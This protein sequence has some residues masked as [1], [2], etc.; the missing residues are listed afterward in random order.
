LCVG[1]KANVLQSFGFVRLFAALL[2]LQKRWHFIFHFSV[3][4]LSVV[5]SFRV[6]ANV[7]RLGD[8]AEF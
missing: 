3:R 6:S 1:A 4:L 5:S 2:I 7:F 8:V